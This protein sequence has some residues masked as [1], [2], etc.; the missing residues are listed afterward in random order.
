MEDAAP[1]LV[2][3]KTDLSVMCGLLLVSSTMKDSPRSE[4]KAKVLRRSCSDDGGL[5][6]ILTGF[7]NPV[8]DKVLHVMV[9][10]FNR[11]INDCAHQCWQ[12]PSQDQARRELPAQH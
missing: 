2:E 10:H 9:L 4:L 5:L 8:N 12:E 11:K 6:L 3:E 7:T 1:P